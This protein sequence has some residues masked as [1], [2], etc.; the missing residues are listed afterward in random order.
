MAPVLV[1]TVAPIQ[2]R[3]N[4]VYYFRGGLVRSSMRFKRGTQIRS[5][6]Q[7]EKGSGSV[8]IGSDASLLP[9]LHVGRVVS[10]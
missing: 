2:W 6:S 8:R 10:P 7:S 3:H 1:F 5:E 9:E 4:T